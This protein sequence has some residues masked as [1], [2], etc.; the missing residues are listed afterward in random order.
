[1]FG[2]CILLF[3]RRMIY[4]HQHTNL[5]RLHHIPEKDYHIMETYVITFIKSSCTQRYPHK[6]FEKQYDETVSMIPVSVHV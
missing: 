4:N 1:M 2:E 6:I 3:Y 5:Q